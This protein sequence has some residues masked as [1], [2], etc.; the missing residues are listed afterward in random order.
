MDMVP[1]QQLVVSHSNF[2]CFSQKYHSLVQFFTRLSDKLI[3]FSQYYELFSFCITKHKVD[4]K[5]MA[6]N[7]VVN[8]ISQHRQAE[9]FNYQSHLTFAHLTG[10][11]NQILS[12]TELKIWSTWL[13]TQV[14]ERVR[15]FCTLMI[16]SIYVRHIFR[17]PT[18]SNI[19]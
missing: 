10:R 15:P 5:Y 11:L 13:G 19:T 17:V 4:M 14:I 18:W 8:I 1:L 3:F 6:N 12:C 9:T 16:F 7:P 2:L